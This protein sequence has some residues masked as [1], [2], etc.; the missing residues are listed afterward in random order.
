[1]NC[2]CYLLKGHCYFFIVALAARR[3]RSLI[4]HIQELRAT[5]RKVKQVHPF[6]ASWLSKQLA[7]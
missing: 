1:M 5:F 3:G 2:G 7:K 4:E 6:F